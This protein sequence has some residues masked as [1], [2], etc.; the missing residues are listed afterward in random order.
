[1]SN[2]SRKILITGGNGQVASALRTH[3]RAKEFQ[4]I[5]CSHQDLDIT[6]PAAIKKLLTQHQPEFIINTAAYT[7]VDKAESEQEQAM[8][9]NHLGALQLALGCAE[10][11]IPLIQLSTDYIFDGEQTDPYKE[12]DPANPLSIYGESKWLGEEA[13]RQQ[14]P[15]HIILRVSGVFSEFGNNFL[16]S[17]LRLAKEKEELRIVADQTTCPTYAGEI[18]G[19]LYSI[20]DKPPEWGTYHYCSTQPISWHDFAVAIVNEAKKHTAIRVKKIS[21]IPTKEYPTPAKRPLNAI[22]DCS[23]IKTE[24][25]LTHTSCLDEL[26]RL[27]GL[28]AQETNT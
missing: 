8:A 11:H 15:E 22:L 6:D 4:L 23:K 19:M 18:A 10:Q 24:F 1:M 20:L 5:F 14:L 16:K 2:Y 13:V 12:N 9:I 28:L 27:I 7:A 26:P 17:I 3:A 21:A 25:N